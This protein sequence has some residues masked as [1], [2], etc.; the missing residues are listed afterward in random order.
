MVI[1]IIGGGL[2]GLSAA[3]CL[4]EEKA[5]FSLYESSDSVGGKLKNINWSGF[6]LD[7]GFQVLLSAYP[8]LQKII[9]PQ[10]FTDLNPCYFD[11]GAIICQGGKN[12]ILADP[13]REK[14]DFVPAVL[15]PVASL[16]DKALTFFLKLK[17]SS[18]S[19][20]QILSNEEW[21]TKSTS[22]FLKEFG[23]SEKYIS[24]FLRPFF[25]GVFG[26]DPADVRANCFAFC[27]KAFGEGKAFLPL[28]GI[29]KLPQILA[30]KL[31]E[32]SINLNSEIKSIDLVLQEG[33]V[34]INLAD[35][36][37]L[38]VDGVIVATELESAYK[39]FDFQLQVPESF[40]VKYFNLYFVSQIALYKQKKIFLNA[41]PN[42][43]INNGVQ[44]TNVS[45]FLSEDKEKHLISVTVLRNDVPE[46]DLP[47]LC[48]EE[49]E[50]LFPEAKGQI[51]FLKKF[52]IAGPASLLN[53][54][55][56]YWSEWQ[57]LTQN[58]RAKLPPN[59]VLAGE[60][61][62]AN[63]AQETTINSGTNAAKQILEYLKTEGA[64]KTEALLC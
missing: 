28:E 30:R 53:Q 37:Q 62:T 49:L 48:Q 34:K 43:L 33:K 54:S 8:F 1:A 17:L 23:F 18:L 4:S 41:N 47:K 15:S 9:S 39:L 52:E 60:Y 14:K 38:F 61:L 29:A 46:A 50:N 6:L 20:D 51:E 12:H 7:H 44:I 22:V 42:A 11:A 5:K 31:P 59:I 10:E 56:D 63:C 19:F 57:S 13:F 21:S 27:F 25:G 26:C 3:L 45:P 64:S 58:L 36:K 24:N 35:G 2:A 40:R 16:K 55:V 32:S